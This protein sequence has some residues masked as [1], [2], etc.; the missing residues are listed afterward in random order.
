V[1]FL[2]SSPINIGEKPNRY[3]LCALSCFLIVY[4]S[5]SAIELYLQEGRRNWKS[6]GLLDVLCRLV[7]SSTVYHI[8]RARN[9]IKH[10]GQP[11]TEEQIL[12][13]IFWEVRSRIL[14]KGRFKKSRGNFV[15]CQNWNLTV[16]LLV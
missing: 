9:E 15:L 8:W 13:V 12:K 16:N 10:G 2:I 11:K 3:Y 7:L 1:K 14:G 5:S 4:L 6:K